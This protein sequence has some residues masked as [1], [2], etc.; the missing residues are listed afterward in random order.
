MS[1]AKFIMNSKSEWNNSK[2]PRIIIESGDSQT[3]DQEN[4]LGSKVTERSK[5]K[6][7]N[8]NN[9]I[10]RYIAVKREKGERESLQPNK[11]RRENTGE[12]EGNEEREEGQ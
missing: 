1:K 11:R 9:P 4:G 7:K 6:E 8:T 5:D 3:T 12:K 10:K 2:I